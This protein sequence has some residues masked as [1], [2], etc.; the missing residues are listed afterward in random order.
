[1]DQEDKCAPLF[2]TPSCCENFFLKNWENCVA[3]HDGDMTRLYAQNVQ[4]ISNTNPLYNPVGMYFK[5]GFC[6]HFPCDLDCEKTKRIVHKRMNILKKYNSI[7]DE[8]AK[9]KRY[10]I[11]CDSHGQ[12]SLI[13]T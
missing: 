12:Y 7:Y 6:W 13:K 8:L 4:E 3:V 2:K 1:M 5:L 9:I 11:F 10:K